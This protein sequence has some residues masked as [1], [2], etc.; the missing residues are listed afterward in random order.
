MFQWEHAAGTERGWAGNAAQKQQQRPLNHRDSRQ[1][2]STLTSTGLEHPGINNA[3]WGREERSVSLCCTIPFSPSIS[4]MKMVT[5]GPSF[6]APYKGTTL[7]LVIAAH[8]VNSS[9]RKCSTCTWRNK[10]TDL[11]TF[12][13]FFCVL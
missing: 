5:Q 13:R 1:L 9:A 2:P 10:G 11:V 6:T 8:V 3:E 7:G 4:F 12:V